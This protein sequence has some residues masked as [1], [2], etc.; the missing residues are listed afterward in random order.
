MAGLDSAA[1]NPVTYSSSTNADQ[2]SQAP[3]IRFPDRFLATRSHGS[4]R[5]S[6]ASFSSPTKAM[7]QTRPD[8][9]N[10][11]D[12][13][14]GRRRVRSLEPGSV[15]QDLPGARK[16]STR[17]H[18]S[19]RKKNV[20]Q[21][22]SSGMSPLKLD[23]FISD[24]EPSAFSDEYD[25][26]PK[27]LQDV[28]RALHFQSRRRDRKSFQ[29][30][31]IVDEAPNSADLGTTAIPHASSSTTAPAVQSSPTYLAVASL[32]SE[33][34][35]SP[36]TRSAPLHP[37]PLSSNGGTT[38]DWTGS[39]SEDERLDRRWTISRGKR[40]D[41]EKMLSSSKAVT[42]KQEALFTDRI[43]RIKDEALPPTVRKAAMVSEQLGRRY[44]VVYGSMANGDPLNYA[45]VVRW[46][47][48]SGAEMQ[49]W[50]DSAEPLTWLK[51]LVDRRIKR[52]SEWHMSALIMEEY[53]KS[54]K[55]SLSST[56]PPR[57]LSATVESSSLEISPTQFPPNSATQPVSA[58]PSDSSPGTSLSRVRSA[59][60][61]LSF[62]PLVDYSRDSINNS[63][64]RSERQLQGWRRSL[65][66]FFDTG[67][68][69]G[70]PSPYH[71]RNSS[72]GL[73]PAS[74]RINFPD[75]VH[76]FRR[77]PTESD[78]GSS[79]A[80]GSQSEDQN[81]SGPGGRRRRA[82]RKQ[83]LPF[84]DL[85]SPQESGTEVNVLSEM[86]DSHD[87]T[88]GPAG[89]SSAPALLHDPFSEPEITPPPPENPVGV[90][91]STPLRNV[92]RRR[93]YRSKSLPTHSQCVNPT[94]SKRKP[95]PKP[96]EQERQY[97]LRSRLLEEMKNHNHR[98]R[99]RMQRVAS[100]VREY[101]LVCSLVK[102]ALGVTY[103]SL[104]PE[105]LDA[106]SHDPSS[107]TSGTRKRRGWS[108]VEDIHERVLRQREIIRIFLSTAPEDEMSTS[109]SVL[110]KPISVLIE[111]LQALEGEREP[112][113][114]QADEVTK[115]LAEVRLTHAIV[116]EEYNDAV[117]HTSVVYPEL[118]RIVEL[119]ESYKDQYQQ[120][121]ELGM[122][123]LTFILD[124]ITPFWRT[125]GKTIGEDIQDF[126]IIP[127]YRNEF[128]GE[129]KRYLVESL[130]RRSIR[131]WAALS[132]LAVFTFFVTFL[133][134]RAAITST[135]HYRLLWIDNQ[136][137]RWTIIP[138]FWMA[139]VIQWF[140]VILE[141]CVVLL[142]V[143]VVAWWLGWLVGICT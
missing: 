72:G 18:G 79:S 107:V 103:R 74:S 126:L 118:S 44:N 55:D 12:L 52:R 88:P 8:P 56:P 65:P 48:G 34:D 14:E 50:L 121:W 5:S 102:P 35:F 122:D 143:A 3:R 7:S 22:Q 124:N 46:Y 66:G 94:A 64:P 84:T 71:N 49:A 106:I 130:P 57:S 63:Q 92:R 4:S 78:E 127:W 60:G 10:V 109:E 76:R 68:A 43:A 41:K 138:F 97:E 98:L 32:P 16:S 142:Q 140:A 26:Y 54:K 89:P 6:S 114:D 29:M 33:V 42:E 105:L 70:T 136:G 116:K 47:A 91:D 101:D 135:W 95:E 31:A 15:E 23:S 93:P 2:S 27:I 134:T 36:S 86:S 80:L 90:I 21:S 99:H 129:P 81:D 37:V 40:K 77:H 141:L 85:Q 108:A 53:V 110:D 100:D 17:H 123:A 30:Q 117:S 104:P 111:K 112:L 51:H 11:V 28:Q 69:N 62:G 19:R 128:T 45:K 115:K 9:R 58:P 20:S 67:S 87:V 120:V 137:F 39:H 132:C 38:L 13:T 24:F 73:S 125:Y 119:E 96:E 113:Q 133:Q 75:I 25:L 59:N 61:H 139:I 131:H 83:R 82:K 1:L